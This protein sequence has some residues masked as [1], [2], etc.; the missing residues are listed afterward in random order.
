MFVIFG[1]A[2]VVFYL[3]IAQERRAIREVLDSPPA[4]HDGQAEKKELEPQIN[5][6]KHR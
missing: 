6:D 4:A 3:L 2:L 1:I 5:T